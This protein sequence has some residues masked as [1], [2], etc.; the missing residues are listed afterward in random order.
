MLLVSASQSE[1]S[2]ERCCCQTGQPAD[3]HSLGSCL[4][5]VAAEVAELAGTACMKTVQVQ[6]QI[7]ADDACC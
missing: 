6:V 5:E 7:C 4:Q 2:A 1:C 3:W